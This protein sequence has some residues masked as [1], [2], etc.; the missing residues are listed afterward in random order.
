MQQA[1]SP[2][3]K[4]AGK[5]PVYYDPKRQGYFDASG[6]PVASWN[7]ATH[8]LVQP[9]PNVYWNASK[10]AYDTHDGNPLPWIEDARG[11]EGIPAEAIDP[12]LLG[13]GYYTMP[14]SPRPP[15]AQQTLNLQQ[16]LTLFNQ[17]QTLQQMVNQIQA[18]GGQV[19]PEANQQFSLW[20]FY[21]QGGVASNWRWVAGR[22][23]WPGE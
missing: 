8:E 16:S 20:S 5:I 9:S 13:G 21:S 19:P 3:G 17:A 1:L 18:N 11:W 15:P 6:Q 2:E 22:C 23:R 4:Q 12:S 10:Q 14:T 7:D